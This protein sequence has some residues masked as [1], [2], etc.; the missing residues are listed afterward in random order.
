MKFKKNLLTNDIVETNITLNIRCEGGMYRMK[1]YLFLIY[2][3]AQ[4]FI[5]MLI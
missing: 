1:A 5:M 2:S 4:S 3:F